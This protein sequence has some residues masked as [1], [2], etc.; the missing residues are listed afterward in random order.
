MLTLVGG[1]AGARLRDDVGRLGIPARY[2]DCANETR[3]CTTILD[4]AQSTATEL[5]PNSAEVT[6]LEQE[7]FIAAFAEEGTVATTVVLIGSLPLGTRAELYDDLLRRTPGKFILD[8]RGPE[9]LAALPLEPFLVK[10]NRNELAATL[11]RDLSTDTALAVAMN[12]L[13]QRGAIWVVITDGAKPVYASSSGRFYRY[14]PPERQVVN[15]IGCGDCMAAGIA[16]A[17]DRGA[18][19]LDAIAYGMAASADKLGRLLPGELDHEQVAQIART[20]GYQTQ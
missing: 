13:N 5:V 16:S 20:I 18:D 8:A 10:P 14:Q 4:L 6:A 1:P 3:T 12:D 2:I 11:G 7:A 19:P 9:L 15:P 17:I